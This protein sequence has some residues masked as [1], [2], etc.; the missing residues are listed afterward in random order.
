MSVDPTLDALLAEADENRRQRAEQHEAIERAYTAG[1]PRP[2]LQSISGGKAE[3]DRPAGPFG[4][5]PVS[6]CDPRQIPHRQWIYG[7]QL[8]RGFVTLL[9]APGGTGKSSLLLA[10]CLSVASGRSLLGPRIY[11]QCN[12]AL[13]NLE[14]PQEEIDRRLTALSI[15]YGLTNQDIDGRFFVPPPDQ[16]VVIAANGPDG[17]SVIHPDEKR[18]KENVM[19]EHIGVLAVDPFA[20]SHTLEENSNP[21]M[22]QAAAAWRRIA[23]ECNCAVILAHHVRKGLVDSIEAARGAKALTDSARIGLLLST[24]TKEEADSLGIAETERLQYVRLDDAKANMSARAPAATWFHLDNVTL[25]N[26]DDTYAYGDQ[27]VVVETWK[28]PSLWD[29]MTVLEANQILDQIAAGMPDGDPYTD[30]RR[31][32]GERWGGHILVNEL[33]F[34][35]KQAATCLAIWIKNGVLEV[36]TYK[37]N[38]KER[39]ALRVVDSKRPGTT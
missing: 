15:R 20:E 22:V 26:A 23:R 37:A 18:I 7:T 8:I 21:A 9:I 31:G 33:G 10:T 13:L 28:P 16:R 30:N 36:E 38:R 3:D 35:V 32:G 12:T 11:Q 24:M 6:F 34:T 5:R 1:G 4:L 25:D 2:R 29:G 19:D 17:F 14:D 27:V 39:N